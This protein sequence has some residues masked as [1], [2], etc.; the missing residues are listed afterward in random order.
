MSTTQTTIERS[1]VVAVMGHVDHGKSTLLDYIRKTN[2][3]EGEAGG[4][5]QHL[6]TYEVH[7]DDGK[8]ITFIDTPGHAAFDEMRHRGG[9][10][11]DIAILIV[12]AEDG[13]KMQ[14]KHAI[15]VIK[16]NKIPFIVAIN[17]IDKPNAQP[18][19]VKTELMEEGIYVEGFGGDTPVCPIS[20][21]TG[22]GIDTLLETLLIVAEMEEMKGD[23]SQ[24]AT[25]FVI[26]AHR[27]PKQGISATMIIKNGL[28]KR[29]QYVVVDDSITPTRMLRDFMGQDLEE[30]HFSSPIQL[31]GF[32]KLPTIGSVFT[33]FESKKDAE[34]AI[35]EFKEIKQEL[36]EARGIMNIPEGVALIPIILK[37]DVAGTGEAITNEIEKLTTDEVIFKVIKS[38]SGDINESDIKLASADGNTV[39]VG[40]HVGEDSNINYLNDY[41]A[42]TIKKYDII[43]ELTEYLEKLAEERRIKK[44]VETEQGQVKILKTFSRQKDKAV[45]GGK[46]SSGEIKVGHDFK[47]M[48]KE[49]IA[50]YGVITG[51]QQGKMETNNVLEGNECGI[52]TT[53]KEEIVE[54]DILI[55]FV[56][57]IK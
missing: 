11:A 47:I 52:M 1:P 33:T 24:L 39:I 35:A 48:R 50:G 2:V 41:E 49:G 43:Y 8:R 57:E 22:D 40:F 34:Q 15:E 28:M 30:A 5:T 4:I 36:E 51:L 18:D 3:V 23:T 27:D 25:G 44:E 38:E 37:T 31:V 56:R 17:K 32:D 9:T 54:G 12:S 6:S 13:V 55:T 19:R 20:A 26:E 45:I 16:K 10:V 21:K 46:V 7:M 14:T 29:G 53:S 42:T